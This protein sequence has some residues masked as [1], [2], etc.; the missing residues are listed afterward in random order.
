MAPTGGGTGP[1]RVVALDV[2]GSSMKGVV[3]TASGSVVAEQRRPTRAG[4]GTDHLVD[5]IVDLLEHLVQEAV[6][7]GGRPAAVGL[8]VPG[9]VDEREGIA[10]YSV[11]LHWQDLPLRDIVQSRIHLPVAFGHDVRAGGYAESVLGAGRGSGDCLFLA[12][13]TGISGAMVLAGRPYSGARGRAGEIG[14]LQVEQGGVACACA[15][16][17]CLETVAS[18]AA[19]AGR[20]SRRS[21]TPTGLGAANVAQLAAGGDTIA[22]E[23]L[24]QAVEALSVALTAYISLLDPELVILG[25]GLGQAPPELLLEPLREGVRSRLSFQQLPS[26]ATAELGDASGCLGAALLA[27]ELAGLREAGPLCS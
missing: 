16:R 11:N 24:A 8:V 13:G 3:V 5:G 23:V 17:G 4:S 7:G 21:G 10:R 14:H 20:Y 27:L 19:I 15:S 25:G 12:L 9:I 2:G 1:A 22:L 18:A 26:F 6:R